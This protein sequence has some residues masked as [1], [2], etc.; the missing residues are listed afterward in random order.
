VYKIRVYPPITTQEGAAQAL[1]KALSTRADTIPWISGGETANRKL[2]IPLTNLN[3]SSGLPVSYLVYVGSSEATIAL[4]ST[5]WS[6]TGGYGWLATNDPG[7]PAVTPPATAANFVKEAKIR[8]KSYGGEDND[9]YIFRVHAAAYYSL[10]FKREPIGLDDAKGTVTVA[11]N[12][13]WLP[14][15]SVTNTHVNSSTVNGNVTSELIGLGSNITVTS[16]QGTNVFGYDNLYLTGG[17]AGTTNAV[18]PVTINALAS[19]TY[20]IDVYP[21]IAEQKA[22]VVKGLQAIDNINGWGAG[23]STVDVVPI[24]TPANSN[25]SNVR[26]VTSTTTP[27]A[28][29][30]FASASITVPTGFLNSGYTFQN[31]GAS[32]VANY[33]AATGTRDDTITFR[34]LGGAAGGGD[35]QTYKFN[36]TQVAKYTVNFK[37]G[38]DASR[39]E[40][41]T[42]LITTFEEGKNTLTT[43]PLQIDQTKFPNYIIGGVSNASLNTVIRSTVADKNV[44]N[45]DSGTFV[46]GALYDPTDTTTTPTPGV[47]TI[48]S[49]SSKEYIIN[50]YPSVDE[51]KD[52]VVGL[53]KNAPPNNLTGNSGWFT[54]AN[55]STTELRGPIVPQ[56]NG[57]S[58]TIQYVLGTTSGG[59]VAGIPTVKVPTNFLS[60]EYRTGTYILE[61]KASGVPSSGAVPFTFYPR[62]LSAAVD[63]IYTFNVT[64]IVKYNVVYSGV[65]VQ[66]AVTISPT[67]KTSDP[68]VIYASSDTKTTY[69]LASA[70]TISVQSDLGTYTKVVITNNQDSQQ[71][72]LTPNNPSTS[73]FNPSAGGTYTITVVRDT[74]QQP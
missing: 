27:S 66:A 60:E 20:S 3:V 34:P 50:V 21:S 53:I 33:A 7:L 14:T 2:A 44:F 19:Q 24:L 22:S 38:P 39:S 69:G 16:T 71:I 58:S 68:S 46:N 1:L 57:I 11:G 54:L 8:F 74:T 13:P 29:F 64:P 47:S 55:N 30:A 5:G 28:T 65:G 49:V 62:G 40:R 26:V 70:T 56:A 36:M 31:A 17:S 41:G 45:V 18:G 59:A 23:L 67:A 6:N 42:I 37:K 72:T 9:I 12:Y 61:P 51:Q 73:S 15:A 32:V 43:S 52:Q 25:A 48:T 4:P 63:P 10:S 35:D